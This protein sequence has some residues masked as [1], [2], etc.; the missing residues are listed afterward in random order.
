MQN[1]GEIVDKFLVEVEGF[2]ETWYSRSA[3]SIALM[4]QAADQVLISFHVPKSKGV[5][6]RVYPFA[7]TMR[8]QSRPGEATTV[9]GQLE[10]LPL[11]EFKL[12]V[13]P[14]RV[15]CRRKGT[16]RVNLA[17]IGVSETA[18]ALEATDLDEGCRFHFKDENPMVTAWNTIEVPMKAKPKR[19]SIIGEK[20]RY[21]VTITAA[22]A[23]G[24][25]QTVNCELYHNPLIGSWR[26]ILRVVRALII[27]GLI[28]VGIYYLIKLGGGWAVLK[29]N[30]QM[31][32]TQIY[33]VI[34]GLLPG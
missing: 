27:L 15:S 34:K 12:G 9:V 4:P 14:V 7:I 25:A 8:S 5:R 3:S 31:W 29:S 28:A 30:P 22:A 24:N 6:S 2:D 20:K 17:Y 19:G 18:L 33:N 26:P 32:I 16:F 23:G 1:L 21:D 11:V 13:R 10:V